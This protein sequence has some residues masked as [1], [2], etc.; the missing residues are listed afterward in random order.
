[1][2]LPSTRS[3]SDCAGSQSRGLNV[4]SWQDERGDLV[5]QA[6]SEPIQMIFVAPDFEFTDV[7]TGLD[8]LRTCV[9]PVMTVLV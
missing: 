5:W 4:L 2:K 7:I 6:E 3:A 1:M 8:N 9:K